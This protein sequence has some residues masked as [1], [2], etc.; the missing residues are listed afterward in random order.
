VRVLAISNQMGGVGKTTTTINLAAALRRR[1]ERVLLVDSNPQGHLSRHQGAAP[2]VDGLS[3][4]LRA[5][6]RDTLT[7]DLVELV[8]D[9]APRDLIPAEPTLDDD[10]V[11]LREIPGHELLLRE[12]LEQVG[13]RY[14]VA[15]ID[16]A[17]GFDLLAIN[18]WAAAD[19]VLIPCPPE[20]YA[21]EGLARL[22]KRMSG[23]QRRLNPR[24]QVAGIL[25]SLAEPQTRNAREAISALRDDAPWPV[26][27]TIIAK[28]VA[29]REAA[30]LRVE[31]AGVDP[32]LGP[33]WDAV[34][35]EWLE[36]AAV[37]A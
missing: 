27:D 6:A 28:R 20:T 26:F 15:L 21:L 36:R 31:A 17:P 23:V 7:A 34:A 32:S 24:L 13:E 1:G 12:V 11:V 9:Q 25:V 30:S 37:A 2:D 14:D 4:L 10:N 22:A 19:A 35:A 18:A 33:I 3:A 8:A 29:Y 5:A 16:T